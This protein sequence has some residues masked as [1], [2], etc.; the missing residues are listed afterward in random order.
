M[1]TRLKPWGKGKLL[2]N[3]N[4]TKFTSRQRAWFAE[5]IAASWRVTTT[6]EL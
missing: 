6:A 1:D 2:G 3:V 5:F 4:G